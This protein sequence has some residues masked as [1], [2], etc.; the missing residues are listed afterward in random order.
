MSKR[1][2]QVQS[3]AR[4]SLA[5]NV[6][7]TIL[8]LIAAFFTGSV[9]LLSEALHSASDVLS[10]LVSFFSVR[11]ASRPPDDEHPYGHGKIDTLAGLSEAILLFVFAIYTVC[12]SVAR[13]FTK[14]EVA[15][16]DFGLGVVVVC[17]VLAYL[18]Y[19]QVT[20]TAKETESFALQS[21]AQHLQVDIVTTLGVVISLVVTKFTGWVYADPVFAILFSLWLGYSAFT[22]IHKSFHE[23]IDHKIDPAELSKIEAILAREPEL[24]SF[25]KLRTR[26]SGTWHFIDLHIV[27]PRHWTVVEAHELADR[28]EKT[29]EQDLAPAVCTIHVDPDDA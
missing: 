5:F 22:M 7:Q 13:L 27:V 16:V 12:I 1:E 25:H 11:A 28:I 21:N 10:S 2:G 17:A 29:I 3:A 26:H 4:L 6:F 15:K 8:K 18:V 19:V 14:P 23:V 20:K 9:S 24:L